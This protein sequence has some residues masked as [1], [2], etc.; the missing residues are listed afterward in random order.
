MNKLLYWFEEFIRLDDKIMKKEKKIE[1]ENGDL[2]TVNM[3]ESVEREF[4][5]QKDFS[6]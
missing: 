1:L 4:G 2:V 6:K 3:V 5:R